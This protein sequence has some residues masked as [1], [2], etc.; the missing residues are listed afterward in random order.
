LQSIEKR[1]AILGSARSINKKTDLK[2]LDFDK[3]QV[4]MYH[5]ITQAK[6]QLDNFSRI[7]NLLPLDSVRKLK[8][9]QI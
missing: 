2:L 4:M 5:K 6:S 8:L 3:S 9:L 1:L 7:K